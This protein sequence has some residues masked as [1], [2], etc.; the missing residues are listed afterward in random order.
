MGLEWGQSAGLE[1]EA[2]CPQTLGPGFLGEQGLWQACTD[3]GPGCM[4]E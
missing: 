3:H 1:V 4:A 2:L